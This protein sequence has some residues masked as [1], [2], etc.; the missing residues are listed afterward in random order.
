LETYGREDLVSGTIGTLGESRTNF[1]NKLVEPDIYPV[2]QQ[3]DILTQSL[4]ATI[5]QAEATAIQQHAAPET[6]ATATQQQQAT[7]GEQRK[8]E[9]SAKNPFGQFSRFLDDNK[10]V[11]AEQDDNSD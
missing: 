4:V 9:E 11:A 7:T 10:E 1:K 2:P 3:A 6:E 5:Q 8:A